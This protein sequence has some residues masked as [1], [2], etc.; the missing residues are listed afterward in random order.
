[1]PRRRSPGELGTS[2]PRIVTFLGTQGFGTQGD[3]AQRAT[4]AGLTYGA[5]GSAQVQIILP[6]PLPASDP[7]S[8]ADRGRGSSSQVVPL[9][10]K[11]P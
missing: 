4:Y 9:W 6:N 7:L 11:Q 1:M 3:V 8:L 10:A 2:W 5:I